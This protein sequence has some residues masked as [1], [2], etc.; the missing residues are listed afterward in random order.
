MTYGSKHFCAL[1][2]LALAAITQAG[3]PTLKSIAVSPNPAMAAL[4]VPVQMHATGSYTDG[5]T[6]DITNMVTWS[7]GSP[8]ISIS[9]T[10]LFT[11]TVGAPPGTITA[12]L[13]AVSGSASATSYVNRDSQSVVA[14]VPVGLNP[15]A[16]IA[17][18]VTNK[19]Y[20]ANQS[21][22]TVT[23]IDGETNLT[24]TINVG[25]APVAIAVN[26]LTN[27]IYVANSG[28]GNV[29]EID[30]A[31]GSTSTIPTGGTPGAIVVNPVTNQILVASPANITVIDG[32]TKNT[33]TIAAVGTFGM[34]LNVTANRL[35]TCGVSG[36]AAIDIASRSVLAAIPVAGA[37]FTSAI[38]NPLLNQVYFGDSL[39]NGFF[40]L[41]AATNQRIVPSGSLGG[42][43]VALD[44]VTN[45]VLV[46]NG[47]IGLYNAGT[48]VAST[49]AEGF[50]N[51]WNVAAMNPV[52]NQV[53]LVSNGGN[54]LGILDGNNGYDLGSTL[55]TGA[56]PAAVAVNPAT[57]RIY[58]ANSGS[59]TVTVFDGATN[60]LTLF[61]GGMNA[62]SVDVNPFTN[63]AY[64]GDTVNNTVSI[65][66]GANDAVTSVPVGQQTF[67]TLV[68]PIT[69]KIYALNFGSNSITVIDGVT[70]YTATIATGKSP[71][72]GVVN[73]LTDMIYALNSDGSMTVVNGATNQATTLNMAS[74]NSSAFLTS[75]AVNLVTNKVYVA[76][77]GRS[78]VDVLDGATN[79]V[80]SFPAGAD[81]IAVAVNP[82]TN[83]IYTA[84]ASG[85]SVTAINAV[86]G[87]SSVIPLT[88]A[89]D[90]VAVNPFTNMIY[91]SGSINSQLTI[92]A[93]NGSTNEPVI[94]SYP[95][96]YSSFGMMIVDPLSNRIY[97]AQNNQPTVGIDGDTGSLLRPGNDPLGRELGAVA[98]AIDPVHE[99]VYGANST[100]LS[101]VIQEEIAQT[102]PLAV[103][104]AGLPGNLTTTATPSFTLTAV[105]GLDPDS[106]PV[107]NVY[108]RFDTSSA[109]WMAA[110]RN[111]A[112]TFTV[113]APT[114][115]LP[116]FHTLA[117][118]AANGRE[119]T[120]AGSSFFNGDGPLISPIAR[121]GFYVTAEPVIQSITVQAP[122]PTIY[123]G[124]SEPLTAIAQL[125]DGTQVNVTGT[126]DWSS[127]APQ[128][129]GISQ[130][131]MLSATGT[132]TT[133]ISATF[134]GVSA[135]ESIK[136]VSPVYHLTAAPSISKN[137]SG[138]YV[139]QLTFTNTG[140]VTIEQ[141]GFT[142]AQ[143][144]SASA[145]LPAPIASLAPGANASVQLVFPS[146][147]GA[148]QS[149]A[150]LKVGAQYLAMIPGGSPQS[151]P[152]T[153]NYR[154]VLP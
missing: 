146:S 32:V 48:N 59:N 108:F 139:V 12:T 83:F 37:T 74:P 119:N 104:I 29:T 128:A 51:G 132:G 103:S 44:P 152:F 7:G 52:T 114:P 138:N 27:Q 10:G 63:T 70:Q 115:L 143:L 130:T 28:S 123:S 55:S 49:L 105:D 122:Y 30:G 140:N 98:L 102:S 64:I 47:F 39:G 24:T 85:N 19:I 93:I 118:W 88:F 101:G 41:D 95:S 99:Q 109:S 43:T 145:P 150:L 77:P 141:I 87:A 38:Y 35:Y 144:N 151:A 120:V 94:T 107:E 153:A 11:A 142:L 69:N 113:T 3:A 36:I 86:S 15:E 33:S 149:A 112:G 91:A 18:P 100:S 26:T 84:N 58:V 56:A 126:A 14:T 6:R 40:V 71:V 134:S 67:A 23:V 1:L 76:D 5:S 80:S 133:T 81:A 66:D 21:A 90:V 129:A 106:P 68:N 73:P 8:S 125:S 124:L 111:A 148:D 61:S 13:G 20:V 31:S 9:S 82:S 78:A 65:V 4:T 117:A 154:L 46:S 131:G 22:N 50:M 75:I 127:S 72:T 116:G 135:S 92:A 34:A 147:A 57:N 96:G 53:Y 45:Q 54:T 121:Y 79:T 136:V 17:N 89:P 16:I 62:F 97:E 110:T 60:N 137:G 42:G 25:S 2:A